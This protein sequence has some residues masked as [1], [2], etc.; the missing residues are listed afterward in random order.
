[1]LAQ[2]ANDPEERE[3]FTRLRDAWT[4]L[5]KRCELYARSITNAGNL[6]Q[7]L[8]LANDP[9]AQGCK[10]SMLRHSA[11]YKLASHGEDT[12][13]SAHYLGAL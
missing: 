12:K 5:A 13:W 9:R 6:S 2:E 1:M 11:G 7:R 4:T 8:L 3:H 10:S